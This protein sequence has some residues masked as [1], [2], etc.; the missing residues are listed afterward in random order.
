[1]DGLTRD[2][3]SQSSASQYAIN[4]HKHGKVQ[5]LYPSL[6]GTFFCAC[7]CLLFG[8]LAFKAMHH[9]S[10]NEV[11]CNRS[12]YFQKNDLI[13]KWFCIIS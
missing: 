13:R 2:R 4:L 5:S 6:P 3:F 9:S 1:M 7:A 12:G 10:A 8:V 11:I